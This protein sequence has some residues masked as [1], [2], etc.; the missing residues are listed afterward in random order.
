[1]PTETERLEALAEAGDR[2]TQAQAMLEE[3]SA[4]TNLEALVKALI[5]IT[6]QLGSLDAFLRDHPY[7]GW[8]CQDATKQLWKELESVSEGLH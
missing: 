4:T 8:E 3:A 6:Y 5:Q 2:L 7:L 1:M